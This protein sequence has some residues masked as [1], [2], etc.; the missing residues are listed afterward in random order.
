MLGRNLVA[1][2]GH[3]GKVRQIKLMNTAQMLDRTYVSYLYKYLGRVKIFSFII[4]M[5]SVCLLGLI[6][7]QFSLQYLLMEEEKRKSF[8]PGY[9]APWVLDPEAQPT[10]S[11]GAVALHNHCLGHLENFLGYVKR[12]VREGPDTVFVFEWSKT[13]PNHVRCS[14]LVGEE[15]TPFQFLPEWYREWLASQHKTP[16]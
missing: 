8:P 3:D 9:K 6:P 16:G 12:C 15:A 14:E 13:D 4:Y 7:L 10:M 11:Q 1:E 2:R 5:S